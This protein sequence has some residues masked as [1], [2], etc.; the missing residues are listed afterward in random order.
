MPN[1]ALSQCR[2]PLSFLGAAF[3]ALAMVYEKASFPNEKIVTVKICRRRLAFT[4]PVLRF[5]LTD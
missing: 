1:K 5:T 4:T 3:F 2:S